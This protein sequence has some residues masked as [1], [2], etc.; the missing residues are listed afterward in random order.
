[1]SEAHHGAG[2]ACTHD[3]TVLQ[4]WPRLARNRFGVA[5]FASAA[6]GGDGE[7]MGR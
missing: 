7:V 6:E 4:A 5:R 1:M 2:G 3:G